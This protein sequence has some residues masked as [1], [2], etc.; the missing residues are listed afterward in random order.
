MVKQISL[1][2]KNFNEETRD[3]YYFQ[4]SFY[5]SVQINK[6][7]VL[8]KH[9]LFSSFESRVVSLFSLCDHL[10][11]LNKN[12]AKRT[13]AKIMRELSYRLKGNMSFSFYKNKRVIYSLKSF[14]TIK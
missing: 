11:E 9:C 10:V 14:C 13:H 12:L 2:G 4:R 8:S 6:H 1:F 5:E 7:K 3:S